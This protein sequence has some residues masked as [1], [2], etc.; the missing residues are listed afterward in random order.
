MGKIFIEKI[1]FSINFRVNFCSC[2][3]CRRLLFFDVANRQVC[4]TLLDCTDRGLVGLYRSAVIEGYAL[5][6]LRTLD[7]GDW[8]V[9]YTDLEP[10]HK[11]QS[12]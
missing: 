11:S 8:S 4:A 2:F 9:L 3:L 12:K 7:E 10:G 5:S 6:M 1:H